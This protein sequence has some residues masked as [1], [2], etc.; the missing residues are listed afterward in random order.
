MAG[1]E[2][3]SLE[4]CLEKHLPDRDLQEVKRILYGK[5]TRS[6]TL[7]SGRCGKPWDPEIM[8]WGRIWGEPGDCLLALKHFRGSIDSLELENW[9]P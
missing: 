3:E 9:K 5:E 4:Q 8:G 1:S 6:A 7:L 2:W